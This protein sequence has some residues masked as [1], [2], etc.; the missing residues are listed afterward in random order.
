MSVKQKKLLIR[1]S[2]AIAIFVPALFLPI[3]GWPRLV[4]FLFAYLVAGYDVLFTAARKLVRGRFLDEHFLMTVATVGAIAIGEYPE[5][6][7]VMLFYQV[8]E[9]LQSVAVGKSRRSIAALMDIRPERAVVI[10]D[11]A[12]REVLPDAVRIGET[13]V[14][15]PGEKIPL[16][17]L[18]TEGTTTID[19]A[20]LTGES[21]PEDKGVSDSVL[22]GT[23]NLSGVIRIEVKTAYENS[24]VSKILELVENAAGKKARTER[25]I[26]RFA[27][28]YTP[29]VVAAAILL[30]TVPPI[31]LSQNFSDWIYRALVFLVVSCPCALVISVPLSFFGGIG[32]ASR[33]GILIKGAI[34]LETLSKAGWIAFD[35]TG[36]LTKG[37]FSVTAIHPQQI[38][39]AELLDIA[40]AAENY[41]SHPLAGAIVRAHGGHI[42][43][44]RIT[45]VTELAGL[46]IRARIDDRVVHVGNAALME[47]ITVCPRDCHRQGSIVHIAVENEYM[48]HI[49][50]SDEVKSDAKESLD[51]L[52]ALGISRIVMLTGDSRAVGESVGRA[53][54]IDETC[55]ELLPDRKVAEVERLLL[56][57]PENESLVFVGDGVNDAPVLTRADVGIAMGALGSDA[58]IESADIV[59]TDDKLEKLSHA[60]RIAR[61]TMRIVREN[62]A[63]ALAIK[64]AFLA[65]GAFGITTM[66]LA[67]FADVGVTVLAVLNAMRTLQG[68]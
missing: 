50:I 67:V 64:F 52:R 55:A 63:F 39:R 1:I 46:G 49:V 4:A 33:K 45:D 12:E 19:A 57:K 9:L 30:A 5:G 22:S 53:V 23:V 62:I 27:R 60:I 14:V 47:Q 25:F 68:G 59:I 20:S 56:E 54:G 16:D 8:G 24:T 7:A 40:A 31:I 35:K 44:S 66:W 13:I 43:K 38:T 26:T 21:I 32:G 15:R 58:A 17:G 18:I 28:Y 37:T 6:V 34:D 41:S 42:E 61:K 11:G 65:L 3:D 51:S 29:F 2:A 36:T 10:R 48:G